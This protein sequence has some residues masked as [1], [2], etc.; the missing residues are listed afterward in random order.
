MQKTSD[1]QIGLFGS[2][3]EGH[4]DKWLETS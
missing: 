3:A 1:M 4:I 2:M